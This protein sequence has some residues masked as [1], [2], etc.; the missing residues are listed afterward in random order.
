M[1]RLFKLSVIILWMGCSIF[2]VD[3]PALSH[4]LVSAPAEE[5]EEHNPVFDRKFNLR[6]VGLY[7]FGSTHFMPFWPKELDTDIANG[8]FP[9]RG[10]GLGGSFDYRIAPHIAIYTGIVFHKWRFRMG[11]QDSLSAGD[12]IYEQTNALTRYTDPW[13]EDVFFKMNAYGLRF[14][15]RYILFPGPN[16]ESWIGP[17]I[18]I[19]P[20]KAIIKATD[21]I[22]NYG[23]A[24]GTTYDLFI[25]AG[26]N[27]VI[28]PARNDLSSGIIVSPYL[29][30][31]YARARNLKIDNL[32]M[33]GWTWEN[34]QGEPAILPFRLGLYLTLF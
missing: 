15:A 24:S 2:G 11:E 28:H 4:P 27:F 23:T 7:D 5:K 31:G 32:Y 34:P 10:Y 14:G 6:A 25:Q 18:A 22:S 20:W 1:H 12:W 13:T 26:F 33:N 19:T 30:V 3:Q 8:S 16:T 29:E 9:A 17:G 21:Q